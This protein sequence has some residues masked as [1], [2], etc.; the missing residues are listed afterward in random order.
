[1]TRIADIILSTGSEVSKALLIHA[2]RFEQLLH[3]WM[4]ANHYTI[5][6]RNTILS[7]SAPRSLTS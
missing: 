6:V 3:T 7:I 5:H 4:R 1:M 2:S